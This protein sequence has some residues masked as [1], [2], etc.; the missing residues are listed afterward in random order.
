MEKIFQVIQCSKEDK[1]NL[2][3]YM[4]Q[5]PADDWWQITKGMAFQGR[6]QIPW[7][8]FLVEL[9]KDYFSEFVRD[10]MEME[11]LQLQQ[12]FMSV[13]QYGKK[14]SELLKHAPHYK[15]DERRKTR[16][17]VQG[18]RA[19]IRDRVCLFKHSEMGAAFQVV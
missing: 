16:K 17:F 18:L 19:P 9:R 4:L 1:V 15:N 11:F 6:Q 5:G 2:A 3:S 12:G 7:E 10:K 13:A 8:E 14:F